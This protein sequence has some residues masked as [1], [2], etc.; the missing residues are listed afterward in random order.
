MRTP[1]T[2]A[3]LERALSLPRLNRYLNDAAGNLDGALS[4]YESNARISEAFYRPLQSLEVCLRNHLSIELTAAY[5]ANWFRNGGPP[6]GQDAIDKINK[7]IADLARA[8]RAP[9]PGAVIAELNFGFWV[10]ILSRR[11]DAT[12]W[13]GNFSS[14]FQEGGKRIARQRVHNRMDEIRKFRNRVFHHEPIYHQNPAQF[15]DDIIEAIRWICPDSA[16]WAL[17]HSR[18]P[19]VLANPWP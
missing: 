17:H 11:Y 15:H 13:R 4:L 12:L 19:H 8:G 18:V 3:A 2:N 16:D 10:M 1:V 9:T 6:L 14:V 5:T 7:A